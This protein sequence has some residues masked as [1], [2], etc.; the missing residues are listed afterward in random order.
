MRFLDEDRHLMV[1]WLHNEQTHA[2][3]QL[4]NGISAVSTAYTAQVSAV[5]ASSPRHAVAVVTGP[6]DRVALIGV[7]GDILQELPDCNRA[8]FTPDGLGLVTYNALIGR[9]TVWK[10]SSSTK[11]DLA[12]APFLLPPT[13]L[14]GRFVE[15]GVIQGPKMVRVRCMMPLYP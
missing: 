1:S 11:E 14:R 7:A 4:G 6:G 9:P 15:A 13:S 12:R 3:F 5:V 10:F 2:V 8:T